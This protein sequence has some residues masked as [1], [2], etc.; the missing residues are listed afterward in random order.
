MNLVQVIRSIPNWN[1]YT[2]EQL[3]EVLTRKDIP[4]EDHTDWTWKGCAAVVIPETGK[5]FGREGNKSLEAVLTANG[6]TWLVSQLAS[7][8]ALTDPEI[9]STLY[10]L[11]STGL[12]PGAKYIALAVKRNVSL[13]EK[14]QL[15]TPTIT[16][17]DSLLFQL[18][19]EDDKKIREEQA[20]DRIQVYREALTVWPGFPA[21]PPEL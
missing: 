18:K 12:V 14:N 13:V 19:L 2:S 4:Y 1:S 9:Q 5:R 10:F 7:G 6:E 16:E 8:V 11:D 20:L 17:L 21:P 3:L 15:N